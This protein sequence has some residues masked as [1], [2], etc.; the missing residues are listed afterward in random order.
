MVVHGNLRLFSARAFFSCCLHDPVLDVWSPSVMTRAIRIEKPPEITSVA[1]Q[2]VRLILGD[3]LARPH[4]DFAVQRS[5]SEF[6]RA[7]LALTAGDTVRLTDNDVKG[8]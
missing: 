4:L 1:S 8:S 5:D 6:K 7:F 3:D 2:A